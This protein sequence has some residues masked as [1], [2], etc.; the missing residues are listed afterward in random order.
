MSYLRETDP[1][2]F[3]ILGKELDRQEY[4]L[5]M[6]ASEVTL[7]S[8]TMVAVSLSICRRALPLSGLRGSLGRTM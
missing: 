2:I 4:G 7:A 5:E 8:A 6:I 1:E 3:E